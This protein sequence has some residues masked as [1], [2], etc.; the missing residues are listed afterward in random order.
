MGG[1]TVEPA[2]ERARGGGSDDQG[3]QEL[4]AP[5]LR[6][7]LFRLPMPQGRICGLGETVRAHG[8]PLAIRNWSEEFIE[9]VR[10]EGH[11]AESVGTGAP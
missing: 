5:C 3:T 8:T 7:Q 1:N 11:S 10:H 2:S 6:P 9:G 4:R